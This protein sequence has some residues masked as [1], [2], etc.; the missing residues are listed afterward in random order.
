MVKQYTA[1]LTVPITAENDE[2]A[3]SLVAELEFEL[4]AEFWPVGQITSELLV[5]VADDATQDG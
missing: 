4:M 1:V 5:P 3:A 2:E